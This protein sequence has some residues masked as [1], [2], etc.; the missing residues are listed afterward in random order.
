M[1]SR[2]I[3]ET[4]QAIGTALLGTQMKETEAQGA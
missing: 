4:M 2:R 3:L 1:E